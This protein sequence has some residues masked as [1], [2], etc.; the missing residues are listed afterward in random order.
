MNRDESVKRISGTF[1]SKTWQIEEYSD[2]EDDDDEN[3]KASSV[4]GLNFIGTLY[5]NA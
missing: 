4:R 1:V 5:P 3:E 2:D